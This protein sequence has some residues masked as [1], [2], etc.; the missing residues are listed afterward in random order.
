MSRSSPPPRK[1]ALVGYTGVQSLDLVGPF[2]VFSMANRF[3]G[4]AAYE[5]ILA[6]PEGGKVARRPDTSRGGLDDGAA[7][8]PRTGLALAT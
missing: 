2:E 7:G 5:P 4:V 6:S 8:T 3:G 1:I